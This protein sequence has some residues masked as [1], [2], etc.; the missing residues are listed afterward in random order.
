MIVA[1]VHVFV[2]CSVFFAS[3]ESALLSSNVVQLRED[4]VQKLSCTNMYHC[5]KLKCNSSLSVTGLDHD[6][7]SKQTYLNNFLYQ[8]NLSRTSRITS[9]ILIKRFNPKIFISYLHQ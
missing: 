6:V 4:V 8:M 1:I 7:V 3:E 2:L 9:F 5:L